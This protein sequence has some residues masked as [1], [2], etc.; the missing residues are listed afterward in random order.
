[1]DIVGQPQNLFELGVLLARLRGD[2]GLRA[3]AKRLGLSRS[4]LSRW[5]NTGRVPLSSAR[6]LDQAYDCSG[7]LEVMITRLRHGKW[8]PYAAAEAQ[9]HHAHIWPREHEGQVWAWVRPGRGRAGALHAINLRWGPWRQRVDLTLGPDGLALMT[10]KARD[11]VAVSF[12]VAVDP[13]S[14]LLFG[15][16]DC[17]AS[18]SEDIRDGW[19]RENR[20]G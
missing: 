13:D 11:D 15:T 8:D 14:Y 10:G 6:H 7:A 5:E 17:N 3:A 16:G 18:V 19:T 2:E 4:T 12:E 9:G 20:D 1:M